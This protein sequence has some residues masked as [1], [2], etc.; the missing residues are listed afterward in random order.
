MELEGKCVRA[1]GWAAAQNA[2]IPQMNV[3]EI[4]Y[5]PMRPKC[6]LNKDETIFK[7]ISLAPC[8]YVSHGV[9]RRRKF[10]RDALL[11]V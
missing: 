1:F 7:T 10:L 3:A 9:Q 6:F 11:A 4:T 5:L 2:F 8:F